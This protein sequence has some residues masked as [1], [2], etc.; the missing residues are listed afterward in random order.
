MDWKEHFSQGVASY[1]VADFDTALHHFTQAAILKDDEY[2]IY[3]SRAA[4]YEKTGRFKDALRDAKKVID[5]S[6]DRWHG[7]ARSARLFLRIGKPDAALAM[8]DLATERMGQKDA[9]KR[10]EMNT[11]R[12]E[13]QAASRLLEKRRRKESRTI[14]HGGKLPVEIFA[15]IFLLLASSDAKEAILVSH[16]CKRWRAVATSLPFLWQKL[17]L[18]RKNPSAKAKLWIMRSQGRISELS[19]RE[20]FESSRTT[21]SGVLEGFVWGNL[22]VCR[23]EGPEI[24]QEL[25]NLLHS[26]PVAHL[27]SHLVEFESIGTHRDPNPFLLKTD[28]SPLQALAL[29]KHLV[30]WDV[31]AEMFTNLTSLAVVDCLVVY[32]NGYNFLAKNTGLVNLVLHSTAVDRVQTPFDLPLLQCL[33]VA[34]CS[35]HDFATIRMPSLQVLRVANVGHG[36]AHFFRSLQAKGLCS[37]T[38]LSLRSVAV[39]PATI[40]LILSANTSLEALSIT[41]MGKEINDLAEFLCSEQQNGLQP[42]DSVPRVARVCPLLAHVDFSNSPQL[43]SRSVIDLVKSRLLPEVPNLEH[44]GDTAVKP[45]ETLILDKCPLIEFDVQKWLRGHVQKLS[46]VYASA[47]EAGWKR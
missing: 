7:Y 25:W 34:G 30:N 18:G 47:K 9:K 12:Q 13:V 23:L 45:L 19:I 29:R 21:L 14:Y 38:E 22:R 5:I 11:L 28:K 42:D 24:A 8:V 46:C 44:T 15:E 6:P 3:D 26:L 39:S 33:D 31:L 27:L 17:E 35:L 41:H 20:S 37:L 43:R 10:A 40:M 36:T 1:R 2:T 32:G 4:I 16:V